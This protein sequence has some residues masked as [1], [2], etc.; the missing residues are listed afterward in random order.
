MCDEP[1]AS[2]VERRK[3][4]ILRGAHEAMSARVRRRVIAR[5]GGAA[6]VVVAMGLGVWVWTN[7]G[8]SQSV[9]DRLV[10]RGNR[11]A[12]EAAGASE[13]MDQTS[14]G[15]ARQS[16]WT[17]RD[18]GVWEYEGGVKRVDTGGTP[19]P[20]V[21]IV[22]DDPGVV[23]R[24]RVTSGPAAYTLAADEDVLAAAEQSGQDIGLARVGGRVMVASSGGLR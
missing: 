9:K 13:R 7:A 5:V 14:G 15:R 3:A 10:G 8:A 19:M 6:T 1:W 20:R 12:D 23:E 17:M 22:R 16:L 4:E 11:T 24:Y 18:G 2:E 21:Q